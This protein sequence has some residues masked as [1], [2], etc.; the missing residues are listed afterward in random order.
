MFDR[1]L[2]SQHVWPECFQF[3]C[4][5]VSGRLDSADRAPPSHGLLP[6][7]TV[8]CNASPLYIPVLKQGC[9]LT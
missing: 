3:A 4:V 7:F 1:C 5:R 9:P 8:C 2:A 6:A